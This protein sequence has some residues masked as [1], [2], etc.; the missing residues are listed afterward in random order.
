MPSY[1]AFISYSH[2]KDKPLAVALQ[3]AVSTSWQALVSPPGAP[4][5]QGRCQSV[6]HAGALAHDR[7]GSYQFKVPDPNRFT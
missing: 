4:H 3:T 1:D 6:G 2:A 7:A 5:L